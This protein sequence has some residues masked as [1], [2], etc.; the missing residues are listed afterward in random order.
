MKITPQDVIEKEFR[1][2]FRGFD[3][4]EVDTF[5]EEVAESFFKLNEENTLLN[6][7]ILA[8]QEGAD[9]GP[10][11]V[12]QGL[13]ELPAELSNFLEELKQDTAAISAE[14]VSLKQDRS[15]IASLEKNLK[16]A[17][18]SLIKTSQ[19][20]P[21]TEQ[22]GIPADLAENLDQFQKETKKI[23]EELKALKQ[24]LGS[25]GQIRQ[26]IKAELQDLF[27]AHFAELDAR[28]PQAASAEPAAAKGKPEAEPPVEKKEKLVAAIIKE[29]EDA[30]MSDDTRLPDYA[31]QED[32]PD[33]VGLDF[34]SED[35]ILDV[36]KLRG[37]FQ[38]VLDDSVGEEPD[39]R[40]DAADSGGELLF[41]D[42][43]DIEV[44]PEPEVT[45]SVD[46][47]ETGKKTEKK[48]KGE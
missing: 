39:S 26:E 15:A 42:D 1:V 34:L 7:K 45:F 22:P 30:E 29:A 44:E 5:L 36:D 41:F 47:E 31:A 25:V 2:K 48:K 6:E 38:S 33:D 37:V 18:A 21:S 11:E 4:V 14:L 35:D 43:T 40:A 28:L 46:E 24:E 12:P 19:E 23:G 17:I 10:K 13:M 8:L 9:S 16:G 3:M 27:K 32:V 20:T